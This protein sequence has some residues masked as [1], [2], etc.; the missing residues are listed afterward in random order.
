MKCFIVL[1]PHLNY[2]SSRNV[3]SLFKYPLHMYKNVCIQLIKTYVNVCRRESCEKLLFIYLHTV[4]EIVAQCPSDIYR[5]QPRNYLNI[6]D[7]I[8][9]M[10][11]QIAW[12]R[13]SLKR[14]VYLNLI[15]T[16]A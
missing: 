11:L 6:Y 5:N 8:E 16:K 7:L 3:M 15:D 2:M 1:Y 4:L 10:G 14:Y 13:P 12:I 9:C